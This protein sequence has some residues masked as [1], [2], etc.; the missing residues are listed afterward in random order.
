MAQILGATGQSAGAGSGAT[1]KPTLIVGQKVPDTSET[2]VVGAIAA[3]VSRGTAEFRALVNNTNADI[4]FKDEEKTG[5]DRRMTP[6]LRDKLAELAKLVTAEWP[7]KKLRVTEAWDEN[8]EHT[9]TS[10]HYEGR[11]ADLTISDGDRAKLGRLARLAVDAGLDWVWYE[12]GA[13]VH[14]SVTK[15]P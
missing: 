8:G 11:A 9:C 1:S 13:H 2:D 7:G 5:A 10:V 4:V 6:R 14:V 15:S 3:K 12:N